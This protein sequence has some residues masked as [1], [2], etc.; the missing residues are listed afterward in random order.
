MCEAEQEGAFI[1]GGVKEAELARELDEHVLQQ[2]V[3]VLLIAGQ[4]QQEGEQRR[5]VFVVKPLQIGG[6]R[7]G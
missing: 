7:S 5:G 6:H 3:G 2:V 4:I 1:A